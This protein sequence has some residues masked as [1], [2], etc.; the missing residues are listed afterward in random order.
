MKVTCSNGSYLAATFDQAPG[1]AYGCLSP[2]CMAMF[3][4]V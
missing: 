1:A 3:M 2:M 4:A